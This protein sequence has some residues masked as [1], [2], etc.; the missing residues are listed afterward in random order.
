MQELTEHGD[1]IQKDWMETEEQNYMDKRTLLII[2]Q[3]Y[4]DKRKDTSTKEQ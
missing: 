2:A 3:R 4:Y 1:T